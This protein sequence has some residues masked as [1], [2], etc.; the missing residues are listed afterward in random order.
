LETPAVD[1]P[2][3]SFASVRV[4]T[5]YYEE[6]LL[7]YG[8]LINNTGSSQAL[9]LITGT[10]YDGQGQVI[11][12]RE[13]IYDYWPLVDAI[14]PGGRM[15]FELIVDGIHGATNYTLNVEAEPS[16]ESPR[17]NFEFLELSQWNEADDYC[18]QG[19]IRSADDSVQDHLVI[20][21]VLY[22]EQSNVVN[23]GDYYEPY[24]KSDKASN[25]EICVG[26]PNQGVAR[27][28]LRAWG[29]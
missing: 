19:V 17:Q 16:S 25:F 4:H 12:N 1:T 8:D 15:P 5:D 23:F 9:A 27:Y 11:A 2:G 14:P 10:F 21:A 13:S 26:P 7:M 6:G 29:L 20:V 28:E 18:V 3:W 24:L 22:D